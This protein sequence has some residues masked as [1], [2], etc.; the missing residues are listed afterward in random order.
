MESRIGENVYGIS[1]GAKHETSDW[2]G[3]VDARGSSAIVPSTLSLWRY[4]LQRSYVMLLQETSTDEPS[5][6]LGE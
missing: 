2:A 3:I 4:L 6:S 5:L 1:P